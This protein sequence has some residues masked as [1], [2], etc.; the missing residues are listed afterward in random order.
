MFE[1]K[2]LEF[3]QQLTSD[4]EKEVV[5]FLTSNEGGV[6]Y[7]GINNKGIPIGVKNL[8]QD[9]LVIKDRLKTNILPS[10]LGL[11]DLVVENT[12]GKNVIKI[13]IAGGSEKP[14]YIKKY[15]MS[16]K[17]T[18]IR[19]GS[20]S[21]PMTTKLIED[22]YS[23]RTRNSISKIRSPKQQLQFQQLHI[24]FQFINK[25]LNEQFATNLELLTEKE[26]YNYVAYL[27]S[28]SNSVSVKVARYIGL[29]RVELEESNE[30]GYESLIK[31]THQV[32]DKLN[33]E[34]RTL[35]KIT[36]KE[37]KE[38]RLWNVIALREAV[39]N[40]F[41]HNDYTREI[42][43]KFEIF[44]DRLEITSYGGLPDGLSKEEFFY[45]FSVP[46]NKEIMRIFKDLDLVE[47]L[48]SGVPRILQAYGTDCFQFS[49]NFLKITLPSAEPI[50][51]VERDNVQDTMQDTMQDNV[52]DTMQDNVQ[53][54]VQDTMQDT[55]Q[56]NVQDTMQDNV[57]DTM[58]DNVQDTM[59]DTM[60]DNVQDTMQDN[61]QDTMQD[62]VQDTMQDSPQ[63]IELLKAFIDIHSREELQEKLGLLNRDNFRRNYLQAALERE[64]IALTIPD[65]PTSRNQKYYLTEK[66]KATAKSL[67]KKK[68]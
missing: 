30:F 21:E 47:Q 6:L 3:K 10:C 25:T 61:V 28:D 31:A 68:R 58:Q 46:R 43:P 13:I 20:S 49:E 35:A 39:L 29:D 41:V 8:D 33:V 12:E 1:N 14:Y 59:Q 38:R 63:V 44:D 52:Q 17:G 24:Y 32:L 2:H 62:N 66:G 56:D 23:K 11:F 18:F 60:Q 64:Y 42:A 27:M 9:Q 4:L 37:R 48:G 26:E 19:I 55:M 34:N 22:L 40:A 57:Q 67:L 36:A 45:G 50:V 7:I 65:K 15:G 51:L 53:D 5:A 54:N 16:E